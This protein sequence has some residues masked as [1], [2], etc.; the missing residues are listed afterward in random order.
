M[1]TNNQPKQPYWR[2]LE[3]E[4]FFAL[5]ETK[6]QNSHGCVISALGLEDVD[7]L[8]TMLV[9]SL[10]QWLHHNPGKHLV[11]GLVG[12][13]GAGKTTL[14]QSLISQFIEEE[15][16]FIESPTF[17]YVHPYQLS[18]GQWLFHFDL[19]RINCSEQFY[20]MGFDEL[21]HKTGFSFIEWPQIILQQLPR[22]HLIV[23][24]SYGMELTYRNLNLR[25]ESTHSRPNK[26][27]ANG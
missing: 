21:W 20:G 17:S 11:V 4:E 3:I 19:Y 8:A 27:C 10:K 23:E 6:A 18:E 13:L 25:W 2:N 14:C 5:I 26:D 12:Q 24:I 16:V 1:K 7:S 15:K 9:K 22:P